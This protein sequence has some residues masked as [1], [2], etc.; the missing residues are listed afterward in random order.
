MNGIHKSFPG[1]KA[2]QD[3]DL[4]LHS[5]EVLALMGENGAGKSTLIKILSGGHRVDSGE[6]LIEGKPVQ[7][8]S[9]QD[10]LRHGIGVIYQE[11][12][13]VPSLSVRE[14]IF[15]GREKAVAGFFDRAYEQR[16]GSE[17]FRRLG[18]ELDLNAPCRSLT[19]AQQQLV[20]IVK[21]LSQD[22]RMMIMDEPSAA[23]TSREIENLF[24]IITELKSQGH[25]RDL[26][27]SSPGRDL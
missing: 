13:L 19:V 11:F 22:V 4:Q 24:R 9:P 14:N 16:R 27:Q 18:Y 12:N 26:H 23:L 1:V 25:R 5:G 7:I 15:L 8:H 3:V 10:A 2:L 17:I 20:E 6:I 21:A